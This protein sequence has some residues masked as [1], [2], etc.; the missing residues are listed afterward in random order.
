MNA[1]SVVKLHAPAVPAAPAAELPLLVSA[2]GVAALLGISPATLWR[3]HSASKVPS[4]IK[5]GGRTLW[6]RSDLLLFTE[7]GC[8]SRATFEAML[9]NDNGKRA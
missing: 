3:L 7:L 6:R 5:L 2:P 8:P 9:G 4:P 1:D